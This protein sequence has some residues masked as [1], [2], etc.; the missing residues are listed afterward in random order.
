MYTCTYITV[1]QLAREGDKKR[2]RSRR[3]LAHHTYLPTYLPTSESSPRRSNLWGRDRFIQ[4][5]YRKLD[6]CCFCFLF[7]RSRHC[8]YVP[9]SCCCFLAPLARRRKS[10]GGGSSSGTRLCRLRLVVW[11]LLFHFPSTTTS[12]SSSFSCRARDCC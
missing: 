11:D 2:R 12:A 9:P 8:C 4:R 1:S 6:S 5:R 7:S 10:H 3:L